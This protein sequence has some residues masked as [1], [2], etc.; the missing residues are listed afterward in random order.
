M[1]NRADLDWRFGDAW[2]GQLDQSLRRTPPAASMPVRIGLGNSGDPAPRVVI[3]LGQDPGAGPP[4]PARPPEWDL[5]ARPEDWDRLGRGGFDHLALS[6]GLLTR[7]LEIEVGSPGA[8][9]EDQRVRAALVAAL[10]AAA[11]I[12]PP[13]PT[14][15]E[16]PR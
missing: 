14:E 2:V 10:D 12:P 13:P 1:S 15:E 8:L 3:R 7:R 6:V 11:R 9:S 16:S 5:R 4:D